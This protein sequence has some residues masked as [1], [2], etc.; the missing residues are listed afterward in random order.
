MPLLVTSSPEES[1]KGKRITSQ[2]TYV[3]QVPLAPTSPVM[4]ALKAF[5][6]T[7]WWTCAEGTMSG[8]TTGSM[9]WMVSDEHPKRSPAR[10]GAMSARAIE[11]DFILANRLILAGRDYEET[12]EA[13]GDSLTEPTFIT[14]VFSSKCV[15]AFRAWPHPSASPKSYS[16]HIKKR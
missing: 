3:V 15:L 13:R 9:R 16:L 8:S 10:T 2:I 11:S 12:R 5:P 7:M 1:Y 6:P 14:T 4:V